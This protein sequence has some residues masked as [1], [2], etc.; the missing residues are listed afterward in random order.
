MMQ[1]ASQMMTDPNIQNFMGQMMQSF[2]GGAAVPPGAGGGPGAG[3]GRDD[4]NQQQAAGGANP[5]ENLL[6]AGESVSAAVM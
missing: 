6:R 2:M 5:L 3:S 1:M 4:G